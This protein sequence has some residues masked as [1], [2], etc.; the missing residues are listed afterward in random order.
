MKI[1]YQKLKSLGETRRK[2]RKKFELVNAFT[3]IRNMKEEQVE[4]SD[5]QTDECEQEEEYISR[6]SEIHEVTKNKENYDS[7][8]LSES[9]FESKDEYLS[10]SEEEGE[11][12]VY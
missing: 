4:S 8:S 9:D 1:N 2:M 11:E 6:F 10:Q 3:E 7:T 5:E 12:E